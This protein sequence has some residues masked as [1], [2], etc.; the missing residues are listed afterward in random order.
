MNSLKEAPWR[1]DCL[2]HQA[3]VYPLGSEMNMDVIT[4]ICQGLYMKLGIRT[5]DLH[6]PMQEN[7]KSISAIPGFRQFFTLMVTK[8]I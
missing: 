7:G 1:L 8:I 2:P 3:N 6:M 5:K 4:A